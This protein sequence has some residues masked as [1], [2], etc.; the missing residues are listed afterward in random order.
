[1]GTLRDF[2]LESYG[3]NIYVETGTGKC[4][5]L[6]KAVPH[7]SKCFSVDMDSAL[8]LNARLRFPS[9]NIVES[10][11]IEALENWL[12]NDLTQQD[13]VFFFL[14]AHFPGAD[15]YGGKHDV[16][17]PNA[18]PLEQ[19]LRLIQQYRPNCKDVIVCDDARIYTI[20][21]F[22]AGNVEWLQVPGGYGFVYDLFPDAHV[23]LTHQEEGY[24]VID[25]R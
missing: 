20:S 8:A 19:E 11:S 25:R 1:M 6:S 2:Q 13:R 7:F 12:K 3:C 15:F 23:S 24:I 9:V 21:Q 16:T 14:D 22:E 18:V 4:V 10:L 17:E 5:T